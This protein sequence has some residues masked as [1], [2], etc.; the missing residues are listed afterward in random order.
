MTSDVRLC[1]WRRSSSEPFEIS[2]PDLDQRSHALFQPVLAR[3]RERLL[4]ALPDLLG[5]DALLQAVVARQEQIVD[6]LARFRFV[7]STTSLSALDSP[8]RQRP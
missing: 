5:G 2:E 8:A 6:L 7:H 1:G 3:H 4:V